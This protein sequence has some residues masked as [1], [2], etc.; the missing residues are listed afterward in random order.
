MGNIP[1]MTCTHPLEDVTDLPILFSTSASSLQVL[2][3]LRV[4]V[5]VPLMFSPEREELERR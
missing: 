1:E 3:Q 5:Q 2:S 4:V